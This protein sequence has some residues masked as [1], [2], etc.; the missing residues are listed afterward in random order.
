MKKLI[1]ILILISIAIPASAGMSKLY[2]G[3]ENGQFIFGIQ[4]TVANVDGAL[5]GEIRTY[6]PKQGIVV[7]GVEYGSL[8][9]RTKYNIHLAGKNKNAVLRYDHNTY[10]NHNPKIEE[11]PKYENN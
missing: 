4:T 1:L 2:V 10:I 9:A 7:N 11:Y 6:L 5:G 3:D 8:P